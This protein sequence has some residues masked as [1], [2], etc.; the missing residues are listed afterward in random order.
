MTLKVAKEFFYGTENVLLLRIRV[1][2]VSAP[3]R[4]EGPAANDARTSPR[5]EPVL[6]PH[7]YGPLNLSAIEGISKIARVD[8][9]LLFPQF[10]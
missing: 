2:R 4:F 7:I 9:S 3:I 1:E 6:F 8:H 5:P 10:S